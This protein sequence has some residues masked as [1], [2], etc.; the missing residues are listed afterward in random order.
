MMQPNLKMKLGIEGDPVRLWQLVRPSD[1][2]AVIENTDRIEWLGEYPDLKKT[3]LEILELLAHIL[4]ILYPDRADQRVSICQASSRTG[5]APNHQTHAGTTSCSILDLHY[6]TAGWPTNHTQNGGS[7]APLY[8]D[9]GSIGDYFDAERNT[10]FIRYLR[11]IYPQTRVLAGTIVKNAMLAQANIFWPPD[12]SIPSMFRK[13]EARL[14]ERAIQADDNPILCH[15]TH[16]HVDFGGSI[17]WDA[18]L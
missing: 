5:Y 8:N 13:D 9:N 4:A 17:N 18:T 6:F 7:P 10:L 14:I 11:E 15:N 12:M 16:M 1:E 2:I 3:H